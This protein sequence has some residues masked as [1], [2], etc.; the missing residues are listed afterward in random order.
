MVFTAIAVV[1]VF[2]LIEAALFSAGVEPYAVE[3]DPYVGFSS[4]SPLFAEQS[5]GAVMSTRHAKLPW[6]NPQTFARAKPAGAYRIFC[7][8]GSTTYGRPFEDPTSFCGWLRDLLP[9]ADPSR[10]WEV[11]NAGGISYASYRVAALVKELIA[12]EPDLLVVY[13][14]HNEFLER[15]TYAKML[16]TP[17]LVRDLSTLTAHTRIYSAVRRAIEKFG[18]IDASADSRFM[19]PAEVE[20]VLDLSVGPEDYTR[21]EPLRRSVAVHY[22]S[23]L[24]RIVRIARGAGADVV[25]V[26]PASNLADFA[27]FKS[28]HD[29]ALTDGE[30]RH[31]QQRIEDAREALTGG[32]FA[33]A[34]AAIDAALAI[35]DL[36][37]DAH[38]IRGRALLGLDAGASTGVTEAR[39][40]F[41]RAKDE[42]V[43]PLRATD[44]LQAVARAVASRHDVAVV[45][46]VRIAAALSPAGVPG[47]EVFLDHVHPR[48]RANGA[49]AEAIVASMIER[50]IVEPAPAWGPAAVAAAAG[51]IEARTDTPA[52]AA[53]LTNLAKVL[54]WAGKFEE[55]DRLTTR[56][57]ELAPDDA[58]ALYLRAFALARSGDTEAA[59]R[60]Y[61][62][63]IRAYPDHV[64]ARTNLGILHYR[65]G[66]LGEAAAHLEHAATV[67]PND[68]RARHNLGLVLCAAGRADAARTELEAAAA[69]SPDDA[70]IQY[71]LGLTCSRQDDTA[72]ASAQ[73]RRALALEPGHADAHNNLG[74]LLAR[75]RRWSEARGHFASALHSDPQNA[76]A[77]ANLARVDAILAGRA[78]GGTTGARG[79]DR[80]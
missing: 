51:R 59:A 60:Y 1:G 36:R 48:I 17:A 53:A 27:P 43:C 2:G 45:D 58:D 74:I 23:N 47:N 6:F 41:V 9:A 13:S 71:D 16:D 69:L 26:V 77:R 5:A 66:R 30:R 39:R 70:T 21:D 29:H 3:E 14:G 7:L 42:D 76:G 65:A 40:A 33:D 55:A 52:R 67:A 80:R 11:I 24:E 32:R 49:L 4:Y 34:L 25:L 19:L 79:P 56:A 73:Y 18:G 28:E 8:G 61:R 31:A 35:D 37:A 63:S 78:D 15:R 62:R 68:A 72:C 38:Y 22:R 44:Q 64:R 46:M 50:G 57:L 12:Y 20:A 75:Q 10:H 54:A